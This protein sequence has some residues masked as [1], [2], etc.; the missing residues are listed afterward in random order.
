MEK[1]ALL[2]AKERELN[3]EELK[4]LQDQINESENTF[5]AKSSQQEKDFDELR[6]KMTQKESQIKTL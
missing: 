5:R 6:E 1:S 4:K 3:Q 2:Q